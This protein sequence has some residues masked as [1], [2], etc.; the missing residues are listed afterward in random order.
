MSFF[1]VDHNE[2]Q[3]FS[4]VPEGVYEVIISEVEIKQFSSGKNGLKVVHS[5]RKDV[6]QAAKG[7]KVFDNFVV[8]E[9]AMFRF[10]NIAKATDMPNGK[11]FKTED[12][13]LKEFA[14]HLKGKPLKI[15]ITHDKTADKFPEQVAAYMPTEAG[16][17]AG[18]NPFPAAGG[19]GKPPWEEGQTLDI[20]DDDLPF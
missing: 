18:G 4:P 1:R 8:S 2:A 5:I 19:D 12:H 17:A 20:S 7:R 13:F 11:E 6:D 16:Q 14:K 15:K 10:Q 9:K 3:D